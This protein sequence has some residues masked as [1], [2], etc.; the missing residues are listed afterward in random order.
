MGSHSAQENA[1]TNPG[2]LKAFDDALKSRSDRRI[3]RGK[4]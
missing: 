2:T 3:L 4:I 1:P